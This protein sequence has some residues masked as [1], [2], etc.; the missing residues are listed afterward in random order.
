MFRDLADP[1]HHHCLCGY[2]DSVF[3]ESIQIPPE[4]RRVQ[5]Q[6]YQY[7]G[8]HLDPSCVHIANIPK[9][10]VDIGIFIVPDLL[11]AN[12]TRMSI[13]P[14]S[15]PWNFFKVSTELNMIIYYKYNSNQEASVAV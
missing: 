7:S 8:S 1:S 5:T 2:N 3:E 14:L 10:L 9:I 13:S 11:L 15:A 6:K 4:T 12:V